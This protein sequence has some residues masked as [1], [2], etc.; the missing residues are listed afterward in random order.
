MP[1]RANCTKPI[2]TIIANGLSKVMVPGRASNNRKWTNDGA[3]GS[4]FNNPPNRSAFWVLKIC[5]NWYKSL[6]RTQKAA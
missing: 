3:I 2:H 1:K 5:R 4:R 6:Y